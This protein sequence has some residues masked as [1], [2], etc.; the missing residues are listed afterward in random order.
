M[1]AKLKILVSR[2]CEKVLLVETY[3]RF[4]RYSNSL[5]RPLRRVSYSSLANSFLLYLNLNRKSFL[6]A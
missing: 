2:R 4:L 6:K 5:G 3:Y 1:Y